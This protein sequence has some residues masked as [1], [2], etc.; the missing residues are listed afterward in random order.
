MND[1]LTIGEAMIRLATPSG[2]LLADTPTLAVHVGGAESNVAAAVAHMGHSVRWLSRMTDNVWGR[3]IVQELT[4][5][6]VDCSGVVWTPDDRIGMYAVEFGVP[7]RPTRVTY[8]RANSAASRMGPDTFDLSRVEQTRMVHLTGITAALSDECYALVT[9][10]IHKA[11]QFHV[12]VVFDVNYRAKLWSAQTCA[13]RLS[14]LLRKVDTLII[15]RADAAALF[16]LTGDPG[17]VLRALLARFGVQRAVLTLGESGA[18][19]LQANAD[20]YAATGYA[21]QQIDRIG[22]GD[23]FAA[24]VICGLLRNDFEL[25]LKYGTAMSALH[26]TLNGDMF[27]L[28]EEDVRQLIDAGPAN[29]PI[30]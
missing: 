12:P 27:R 3:R 13:E 19:G 20:V 10:I 15:A 29:R 18:A 8:D 23:A 30:R 28:A 21:A 26:M 4:T 17:E 22:A 6:G 9:A 11:N 14:P 2:E 5:Q 7:P 16:G 24:G 1:L 25:G